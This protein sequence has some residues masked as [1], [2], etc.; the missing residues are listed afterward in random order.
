MGD[1]R[2]RS[3]DA[4]SLR[5]QLLVA[6]ASGN[7]LAVNKLLNTTPSDQLSLALSSRD[8]RAQFL[9]HLSG[10]GMESAVKDIISRPGF[11]IETRDLGKAYQVAKE[12]DQQGVMKELK[13]P[14]EDSYQDDTSRVM[15]DMTRSTGKRGRYLSAG[16]L[17]EEHIRP[18]ADN[19]AA[20]IR[21]LNELV[22]S[23]GLMDKL[24]AGG[25]L[26][27]G[28]SGMAAALPVSNLS[29]QTLAILRNVRGNLLDGI[30]SIQEHAA[31]GSDSQALADT[32]KQS[33]RLQDMEPSLS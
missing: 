26:S 10:H 24:Q 5:S 3:P 22:S 23:T 33:R 2:N 29:T 27:Q 7:E 4:L 31:A 19:E 8:D 11:S 12:N 30:A 14:G 9:S 1:H 17:W 28:V 13:G 20:E 25:D 32:Q 21:S 18:N 15:S 16:K 6:A